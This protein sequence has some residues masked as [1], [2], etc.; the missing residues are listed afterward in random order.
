M[1]ITVLWIAVSAVIK[2][3]SPLGEG[4]NLVRIAR[5]GKTGADG[6][7]YLTYTRF[8]S[9]SDFGKCMKQSIDLE[10]LVAAYAHVKPSVDAYNVITSVSSARADIIQT[11]RVCSP[12]NHMFIHPTETPMLVMVHLE[13][14]P[15]LLIIPKSIFEEILEL[16]ETS[17]LENYLELIAQNKREIRHQLL[18]L[19]DSRD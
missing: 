13:E 14:L 6:R 10:G 7:L 15:I 4:S 3:F 16:Y 2:F 11:R 9:E 19:D 18:R 12:I 5:V 1:Q 8:M 17:E